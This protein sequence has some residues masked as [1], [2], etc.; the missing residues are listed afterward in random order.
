MWRLPVGPWWL[1]APC[2]GRGGAILY[3][4]SG[5][6]RDIVLVRAAV[7]QRPIEAC[8]GGALVVGI[9]PRALGGAP[10]SSGSPWLSGRRRGDGGGLG[11]GLLLLGRH[12]CSLHVSPHGSANYCVCKSHNSRNLYEESM[13][14]K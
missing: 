8:F 2:V 10:R 5:A 13:K 11:R 14:R 4:C 12:P 3:G 6:L 9:A 7:D 1:L